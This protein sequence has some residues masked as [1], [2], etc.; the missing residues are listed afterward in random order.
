MKSSR[1]N[2]GV[3]HRKSTVKTVYEIRMM[4]TGYKIQKKRL[5]HKY[6]INQKSDK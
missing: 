6:V 2:P 5:R 1:K 3:A 4:S